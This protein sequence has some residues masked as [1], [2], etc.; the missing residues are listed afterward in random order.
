V[1]SATARAWGLF[2]LIQQIQENWESSLGNN[3]GW[4]SRQ[5]V[6]RKRLD[7]GSDPDLIT[8]VAI[9]ASLR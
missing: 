9:Q 4:E 5:Q 7:A 3:S 1:R 6:G 8:I 2:A